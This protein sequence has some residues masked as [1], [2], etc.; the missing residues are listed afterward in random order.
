MWENE[1]NVIG[2]DNFEATGEMNKFGF[3][4]IDNSSIYLKLRDTVKIVI[5][6]VF[7]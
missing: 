7:E 1:D 2:L 5:I 4:L 6:N 3:K